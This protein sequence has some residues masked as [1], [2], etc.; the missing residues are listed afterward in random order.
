MK[1]VNLNIRLSP[2]LREKFK[3]VTERNAQSGA[4]LIRQWIEKYIEE[5][6]K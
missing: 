6:D 2:E 4:A 1:T 5:N 3:E